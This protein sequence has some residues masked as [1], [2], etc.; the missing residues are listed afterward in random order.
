[1]AD[2][3]LQRGPEVVAPRFAPLAPVEAGVPEE[4]LVG[5]GLR[6][7]LGSLG[8]A[9]VPG[10]ARGEVHPTRHER[11]QLVDQ[12]E[13]AVGPVQLP[14]DDHRGVPPARRA[15]EEAGDRIVPERGP[16]WL[17]GDVEDEAVGALLSRQVTEPLQREAGD[18]V[19]EGRGGN[20]ELPVPGPTRALALRAV[21]GDVTGVAPEAPHRGLVELVDALVAA[22][23]PARPVQV[24]VDDHAGHVVGFQATVQALDPHVLE[25]MD[26]VAGLEH[27]VGLGPGDHPIDLDLGRALAGRV[28]SREQVVDGHVPPVIEDLAVGQ[29]HLVA[30]GPRPAEPDPAVDVL[31]EV[32]DL[33]ARDRLGDRHRP[34]P[35]DPAHRR[36]GGGAEVGD[37]VVGDG[38]R[39]PALQRDPEVDALARHQVRTPDRSG[40]PGPGRVGHHDRAGPVGVVDVEL[41]EEGEGRA[42]AVVVSAI[43]RLA[44]PPAVRQHHPQL[45]AALVEERG[46]VV[47]LHLEPARV[48]RGPG[49]QLQVADPSATEERL[50]DPVG[51]GVEPGPLD[52]T[53]ERELVA[54]DRSGAPPRF[55]RVDGLGGLD[56]RG[57]PVGRVEQAGLGHRGLRPRRRRPLTP[58]PHLPGHPLA[59]HEVIGGPGHQHV[60]VRLDPVLLDAV[61]ADLMGLLPGRP[62]R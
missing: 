37:A 7:G 51:G 47:G 15:L 41:A 34:Q 14:R 26:G 5:G 33:T 12:V 56:P 42:V 39:G 32:D 52:R 24:R 22:V 16:P 54:Q 10:L 1:M 28:V 53:V 35:L 27:R 57:G 18:V 48:A 2:V 55:P 46:H 44:P 62:L 9:A 21:G 6:P 3:V 8:S 30:V 31:A 25:A 45:V 36:G 4:R 61:D 29:G 59:G 58:D 40:G 50:V 38:H 20:E 19:E 13:V 11:P 23:E 60:L 17:G 49:G 43:A